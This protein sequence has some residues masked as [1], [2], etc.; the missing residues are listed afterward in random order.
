M[1]R[2]G[3]FR[4]VRAFEEPRIDAQA[5]EKRV[6]W[7]VLGEWPAGAERF[8]AELVKAKQVH[9][10][11]ESPEGTVPSLVVNGFGAFGVVRRTVFF[12]AS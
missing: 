5:I 10:R 9:D 7:E 8:V 2:R 6:R 1:A 4:V 3:R 12:L 11:L